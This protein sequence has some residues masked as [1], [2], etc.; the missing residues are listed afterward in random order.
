MSSGV[1][2]KPDLTEFFHGEV[3][4]ARS[5]LGLELSQHTEFYLVNLLCEFSRTGVAPTP[6]DEP[7]ALLYKRALEAEPVE[8]VRILKELGDLSLYV[9]GFFV[10]FIERSLVDLDYYIS[11]GGNA[12]NNVSDLVGMQR[13][14]AQH[15][16]LYRQLA[17]RFTALVDLLNE[18]SDRTRAE[19]LRDRDLLRL[20]ERWLRTRSE[21]IRKM[22]LDAGLLPTAPTEF[23]D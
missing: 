12:Y 19:E 10:E 9:A 5:H 8:R 11:M 6:G 3:S 22:L 23:D 17:R 2:L 16:E 21:R 1:I 4:E 15:A 20:Y 18:V 7:L 13:G 14:G